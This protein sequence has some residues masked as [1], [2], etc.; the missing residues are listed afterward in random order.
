MASAVELFGQ[1]PGHD[2]RAQ[3]LDLADLAAREDGTGVEVG[4]PQLDM[5]AGGSPAESSRQASGRSIGLAAITGTS[6]AP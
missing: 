6:L 5:P 4:D 3:D 1:V 2:R